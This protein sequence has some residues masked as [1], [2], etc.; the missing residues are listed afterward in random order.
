MDLRLIDSVRQRLQRHEETISASG[1]FHASVSALENLPFS[2]IH[3]LA[4]GSPTLEFQ[5]LFQLAYL[6]LLANKFGIAADKIDLYDPVFDENDKHL[7]ETVLR[8]RIADVLPGENSKTTLY[9]MP[10]APRSVTDMFIAS[11]EP[12]WILGNDVTVTMG[13]LGKARFLAEYPTL[14]TLVHLAE[15]LSK[16]PE[17]QNEKPE[18]DGFQVAGRRR[19]GNRKNVYVEPKCEYDL[20]SMYFGRVT[21]ER[22]VSPGNAPWK[23]SFSDLALNTIFTKS[24]LEK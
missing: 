22:F 21:V 19:R 23:D 17:G 11:I 20:A 10:H 6:T 1:L 24:E 18:L 15:T 3:C 13:T 16:E 12:R 8:Y 9:Y 5:A 14:A 7:L 2:R 4:L